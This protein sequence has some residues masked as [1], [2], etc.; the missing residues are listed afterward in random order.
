MLRLIFN[1]FRQ[2]FE[3]KDNGNTYNSLRITYI[4]FILFSFIIGFLLLFIY[5]SI[6]IFSILIFPGLI[7]KKRLYQIGSIFMLLI[8]FLTLLLIAVFLYITT[9]VIFLIC[10]LCLVCS[11]LC[12]CLYKRRKLPLSYFSFLCFSINFLIFCS[13]IFG[14][15]NIFLGLSKPIYIENLPQYSYYKYAGFLFIFILAGICYFIIRYFFP[16]FKN[17][18]LW[19]RLTFPHLKEEV[20]LIL[21]TW[22]ESIFGNICSNIME[23]V[24]KSKTSLWLFVILH[25]LC[26]YGIRFTQ[27]ILFCNF[28][29]FHGDLRWNLY[30]LPLSLMSWVLRFFEYYLRTFFQGSFEYIRL[31]LSVTAKD[32]SMLDRKG[33]W[34]FAIT[35]DDV[36]IELTSHALEE[37]FKE[38][39]LSMLATEWFKMNHLDV[40]LKTYEKPLYWF[41]LFLLSLRIVAWSS[42]SFSYFFVGYSP[43]TK[44]SLFFT[45]ALGFVDYSRQRAPLEAFRAYAQFQKQLE[46]ETDGACSPGHLVIANFSIKDA[47]TEKYL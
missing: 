39:H 31:L 44:G 30:L 20:R 8:V 37:G 12:Y 28:V 38:K 16:K 41:N 35:E 22:N 2:L 32:I 18:V 3:S 45:R 40:L 25:F 23:S 11:V 13:F 1:K 9:N 17:N 33:K 27:T 4:S 21:Y 36:N 24:F 6:E 46:E 26:F 5:K 7:G 14:I 29:F 19:S 43:L 15:L 34:F 47:I 10:Y 42:L